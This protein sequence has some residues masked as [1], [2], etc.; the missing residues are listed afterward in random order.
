VVALLVSRLAGRP[1]GVGWELEL[2]LLAWSLDE[3]VL[4][5]LRWEEQGGKR[6]SSDLS[7]SVVVMTREM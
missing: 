3:E 1:V 4:L 5:L 2:E 7:L 6:A